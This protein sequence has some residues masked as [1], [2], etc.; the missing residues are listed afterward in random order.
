[1]RKN[2]KSPIEKFTYEDKLTH[3]NTVCEDLGLLMI[4]EISTSRFLACS[5]LQLPEHTEI[6]S[7]PKFGVDSNPL[8][9]KQG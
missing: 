2:L 3:T 1:M 5:Q 8:M 9:G 7:W 4:P 6:S